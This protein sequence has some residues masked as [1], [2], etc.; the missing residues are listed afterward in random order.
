MA[1][2]KTI[3][4]VCTGNT[5]RSYMAEVISKNYLTGLG[6]DGLGIEVISAGTGAFSDEPPTPEAKAVML[7]Q[8][9]HIEEHSSRLL[10]SELVKKA[11]LILVMT[12]RH[13][14]HILK[15]VPE[16]GKKVHLLM[17]YGID[18]E[19][20]EK[21][22]ADSLDI[23]DPFGHPLEHYRLCADQLRECVHRAI[24]RFLYNRK[25]F[26]GR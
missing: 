24:G 3:L 10:T 14:S 9:M 23:I 21:N 2:T 11:D 26:I 16:A 22:A 7:E 1:S 6:V 15:L 18:C 4:F 13:K 19:R 25:D 12:Q 20:N 17:E 8:G 5:C